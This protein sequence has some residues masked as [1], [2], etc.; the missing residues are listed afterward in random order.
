[1]KSRIFDSCL[2]RQ[3]G[4]SLDSQYFRISAAHQSGLLLCYRL[5]RLVISLQQVV[6]TWLLHTWEVYL[7]REIRGS[8]RGLSESSRINL[9]CVRVV[10]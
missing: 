8:G 10:E 3:T 9:R 6:G 7:R 2:A 4:P 1:M 5:G